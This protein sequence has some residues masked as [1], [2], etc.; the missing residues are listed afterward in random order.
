MT[1]FREHRLI[2]RRI[3]EL[4]KKQKSTILSTPGQRM[5]T[6]MESKTYVDKKTGETKMGAAT[7]IVSTAGERADTRQSDALGNTP[8]PTAGLSD[9][10]TPYKDVAEAEAAARREYQETGSVSPETNAYLQRMG[11]SAD[12]LSMD[13]PLGPTSGP[14]MFSL[15]EQ[16]RNQQVANARKPQGYV[17]PNTLTRNTNAGVTESDAE[18]TARKAAQADL[19]NKL[20]EGSALKGSI[21]QD[22]K[23][24]AKTAVQGANT[25][26]TPVD[27]FTQQA[28][29][30]IA[31]DPTL[32]PYFL[33]ALEALNKSKSGIAS[34]TNA[35]L[36]DLASS[37]QNNNGVSDGVEA[38]VSESKAYLSDNIKQQGAIND[39][40]RD[41]NLEA[42][43][44]AKE[45]AEIAKSKFELEQ[46]KAE[47]QLREQNVEN[48]I[49]NRRIANR[50]GIST[51]TNGLKWMQD[52]IRKGTEALTFLQ[53]A[54]SLQEAQFA[55]E[56][57]RNYN[58]NVR[59]ATNAHTATALELSSAL[60]NGLAELDNTISLD[61]K[62]R[63]AER[64]KIVEKFWER[65]DKN[66]EN[67]ASVLKD[68]RTEAFDRIKEMNK[69]KLEGTMNDGDALE[70]TQAMESSVAGM[71][72]FKSFKT[73]N[74]NYEGMLAAKE[75]YDM[76]PTTKGA[77]DTAL[78]KLYEKILDPDSVVRQEEFNS[79]LKA[80]G[81]VRGT[82][83]GWIDAFNGGQ[84]LDPNGQAALVKMAGSLYESAKR[85]TLEAIQPKLA[86]VARFN[87]QAGENVMLE[88]V[89]TQDVIDALDI[90][91]DEFE[92]AAALIGDDTMETEQLPVPT[93]IN[94]WLSMTGNGQVVTGSPF[95][96]GIDANA[97]DIDGKIGDPITPVA[98]GYVSGM[99]QDRKKGYGLSVIV[100]DDQGNEHLYAHMD[101]IDVKPGQRVEPG[102]LLGKMGN[103]GNVIAG[104]K[105]DGSHLHYRMSK[106]GQSLTA[107]NHEEAPQTKPAPAPQPQ[108]TFSSATTAPRSGSTLNV[109]SNPTPQ[110]NMIQPK[111]YKNV[112]TGAIFTVKPGDTD[113]YAAKPYKYSPVS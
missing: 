28:Q 52:E 80:Q 22:T 113:P 81:I 106:G 95:H 54:G 34:D 49:K 29:D 60:K 47:S 10:F 38:A 30:M 37:D 51:D 19:N 112:E 89:F 96:K 61:A 48:E 70:F 64:A 65:M 87:K 40:N 8:R 82:V 16:Q 14:A 108:K 50:L 104:P 18:F 77:Y 58:L 32:A 57:G 94:S 86:Q 41:I 13:G 6:G 62:E 39:E 74:Y 91:V 63:K 17:D 73:V 21:A 2:Y 69:A 15:N 5:V 111:K 36:S 9:T 105:G 53:Q 88:E 46:A 7:P 43:K 107:H 90:P 26:P 83:Q 3:D 55:L 84:G 76:D 75:T 102:M 59:S 66:D 45:T 44:I 78:V 97:I 24:K 12:K 93:D 23:D 103:T 109:A 4:Q 68:F 11:G 27:T 99:T 101:S 92:S 85:N 25:T 31:A 100:T 71:Q 1:P 56:I 42:A 72:E 35:A 98:A 33:P 67:T 20:M 79:Q 110:V